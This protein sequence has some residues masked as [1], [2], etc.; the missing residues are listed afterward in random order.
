MDPTSTPKSRLPREE[1]ERIV[2]DAAAQL[3]YARGVHEVGMDELIEHAGLGKATVY[4]LY[5][6]KDLLIAAYLARTASTILERIDADIAA[7]PNAPEAAMTAIL[8][9][10]WDHVTSES[11]RGCPFNNAS[12]EFDDPDHPARREART[13][14]DEL[15]NRLVALAGATAGEQLAVLIDGVYTNAV[16]L[17]PHGPATVGMDLARSIADRIRP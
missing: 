9:G 7:N 12:I 8:D 10:I 15:R 1:R 3:F 4:R 5:P 14:R 16:H 6:S 2:L 13:Y 11:F 17:G